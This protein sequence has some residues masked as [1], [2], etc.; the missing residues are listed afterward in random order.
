M[1]TPFGGSLGCLFS[2]EKALQKKKLW[3]RTTYVRSEKIFEPF[4]VACLVIRSRQ[5][6]TTPYQRARYDKSIR[7]NKKLMK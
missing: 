2:C 5:V 1:G 4:I 6:I 3:A 7:G